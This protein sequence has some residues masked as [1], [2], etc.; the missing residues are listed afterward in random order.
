MYEPA[1]NIIIGC[2]RCQQR[3][4]IRADTVRETLRCGECG[5][6][7]EAAGEYQGK[8]VARALSVRTCVL[9]PGV[10]AAHA[11]S[12]CASGLCAECCTQKEGEKWSCPQCGSSMEVDTLD[13]LRPTNEDHT[14]AIRAMCV[15]H[16]TVPAA[17]FCV[18]C[19]SPM[20]ATCAFTAPDGRDVCP[21]CAFLPSPSRTSAIPALPVGTMCER[22]TSV[23]AIHL[24]TK[25][26]APIC[27]TC[28]FAFPGGIFICPT[29]A[30]LRSNTLTGGRKTAVGFSLALG[31]L[32]L[33]AMVIMFTAGPWDEDS[34]TGISLLVF[35]PSLAGM[36]LGLS[37]LDK[38][39]GNPPV[40]RVAAIANCI[41]MGIW[42]VLCLIGLSK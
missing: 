35:I 16:P 23:A 38:R 33:L 21:T 40:L 25:C 10:P 6:L 4:A 3:Y 5:T 8:T 18:N 30:T 29:C 34:A 37:S 27:D 11:C 31:A 41:L 13:D 9:H 15:Q 2:P 22:H 19:G 39:L 42:L 24:C 20:C 32:G 28:A 7:L 12:S 17:R 1:E 14:Q 26:S 36:I